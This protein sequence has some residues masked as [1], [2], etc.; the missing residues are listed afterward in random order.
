M[1]VTISA[2]SDGEHPIVLFDSALG[3]G[4]GRWMVGKPR[5]GTTY[6]VE[7]KMPYLRWAEQIFLSDLSRPRIAMASDQLLITLQIERVDV[8]G[9]FELRLG[10]SVVLMETTGI[11]AGPG[12]WID[13]RLQALDLYDTNT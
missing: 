1:Q 4:R 5:S 10:E 6:D 8:E 12:D 3:T 13:V 2:V 9:V 11:P 7:F